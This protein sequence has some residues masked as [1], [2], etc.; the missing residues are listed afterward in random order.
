M[1]EYPFPTYKKSV[2]KAG[3]DD[4][5]H[6]LLACML[7][8]IPYFFLNMLL[9]DW[10]FTPVIAGG[11][12]FLSFKFLAVP[13]IRHVFDHLPPNYLH[14]FVASVF[15]NGGLRCGPDPDPV[16]FRVK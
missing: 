8:L 3:L 2:P 11:A 10:D 6:F 12:G 15:M 1:S 5:V 16:P 4:L 9:G 14:H 13:A 7:S